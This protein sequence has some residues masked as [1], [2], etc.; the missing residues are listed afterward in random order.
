MNTRQ[1]PATVPPSGISI[2]PSSGMDRGP[3]ARARGASSNDLLSEDAY[4][5][6][7]R[8]WR[9]WDAAISISLK[10]IWPLEAFA[11]TTV[12]YEGFHP[13][14]H[15][16]SLLIL[17]AFCWIIFCND[18]SW[19]VLPN[20]RCW[21]LPEIHTGFDFGTEERHWHQCLHGLTLLSV[22]L[23]Q[24]AFWTSL[25]KLIQVIR[26]ILKKEKKKKSLRKAG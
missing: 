14:Q 17:L 24:E 3:A 20:F 8:K 15:F 4:P 26:K 25:F 12:I 16:I 2:Q 21:Y 1:V 11:P 18:G 6:W 19:N 5:R 10:K 9:Q 7:E 22:K 13:S 23:S